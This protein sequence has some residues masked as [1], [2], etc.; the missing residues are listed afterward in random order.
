MSSITLAVKRI[1]KIDFDENT[2][3][4]LH[5]MNDWDSRPK[6]KSSHHSFSISV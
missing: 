3:H 5:A 4:S 1:N 6:M 2:H